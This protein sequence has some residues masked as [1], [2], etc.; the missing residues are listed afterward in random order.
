MS[1][2]ILKIQAHR[3]SILFVVL[4]LA[5]AGAALSFKIPVSLFPTVDFP[6]VVVS[7]DVGDRAAELM[8]LEVTRPVE[9]ALRAVPGVKSVRSTSSR[10]SARNLC[11]L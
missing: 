9:E 5:V 1:S 3:R 10:G 6:R 2:I 4:V 11:R 8:E 7:L